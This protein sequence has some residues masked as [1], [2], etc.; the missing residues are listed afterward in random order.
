MQSMVSWKPGEQ[1]SKEGVIECAEF[2][3]AQG[4][5]NFTINLFSITSRSLPHGDY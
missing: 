3:R 5:V 2:L 4:R 1:F